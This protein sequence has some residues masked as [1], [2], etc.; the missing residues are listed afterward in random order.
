[1]EIE[2][3][4]WK[5]IEAV[6]SLE[7][8]GDQEPK[9]VME[10]LDCANLEEIREA[11]QSRSHHIVHISG[12]RAYVDDVEQGIVYLENEDEDQQETAG[13]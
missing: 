1:M 12:H 8:T 3:E 7:A 11:I 6:R 10:I 9:L 4:Q 13:Y 5:I 2:Q